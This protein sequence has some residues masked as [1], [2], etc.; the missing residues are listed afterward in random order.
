MIKTGYKSMNESTNIEANVNLA[1]FRLGKV[2]GSMYS[3]LVAPISNDAN[4]NTLSEIYIELWGGKVWAFSIRIGHHTY[5]KIAEHEFS[6]QADLRLR[7][8]NLSAEEFRSGWDAKEVAKTLDKVL[9]A[10]AT[11][12]FQKSWDASLTIQGRL[13]PKAIQSLINYHANKLSSRR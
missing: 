7:T 6:A 1:D 13:D 11:E 10:K 5:G 12:L 2:A 9:Q 8:Q 3:G 4:G